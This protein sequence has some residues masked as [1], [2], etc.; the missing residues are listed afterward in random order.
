[1]KKCQTIHYKIIEK[2]KVTNNTNSSHEHTDY[3]WASYLAGVFN[4]DTNLNNLKDSRI[5]TN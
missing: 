3:N 5:N 4:I 2:F 1:M